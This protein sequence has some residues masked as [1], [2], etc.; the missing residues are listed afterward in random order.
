MKKD[1]EEYRKFKADYEAKKAY[2]RKHPEIYPWFVYYCYGW[3]EM[4]YLSDEEKDRTVKFYRLWE[5]K[6]DDGKTEYHRGGRQ[7][8][9]IVECRDRLKRGEHE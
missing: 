2:R 6:T 5:D 8:I 7:P 9:Y 4:T 3:H 1:S